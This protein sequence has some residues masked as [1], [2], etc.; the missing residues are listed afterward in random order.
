MIKWNDNNQAG[1]YLRD[2]SDADSSLSFP[3]S[4]I[5]TIPMLGRFR[6]GV[7]LRNGKLWISHIESLKNVQKLLSNS[8]KYCYSSSTPFLIWFIDN[9]TVK[10]VR[11]IYHPVWQEVIPFFLVTS[12]VPLSSIGVMGEMGKV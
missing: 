5:N 6:I 2:N 11:M 10:F 3:L 12:L 1:N 4:I 8:Q 7:F 9:D